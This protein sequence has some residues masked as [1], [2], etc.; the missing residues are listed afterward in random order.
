MRTE[1]FLFLF[2]SLLFFSFVVV[3]GC[4]CGCGVFF[5]F[6]WPIEGVD[7]GQAIASILPVIGAATSTPN[8]RVARS[9]ASAS[10]FG[11]VRRQMALNAN[12]Q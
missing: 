5:S 9:A 6:F 7:N 10:R 2:F 11:D 1:L 8:N 4:G 3:V 12:N